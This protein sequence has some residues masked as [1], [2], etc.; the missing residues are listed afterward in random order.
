MKSPGQLQQAFVESAETDIP[1][2]PGQKYSDA[3]VACLTGLK[4]DRETGTLTDQDGIVVGL[5]YIT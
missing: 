2:L 4:E 5:A 1:R 3:V